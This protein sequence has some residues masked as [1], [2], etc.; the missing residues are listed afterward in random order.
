MTTHPVEHLPAY[1]LGALG[2]EETRN[3]AAHLL[4][5]P[6]CREEVELFRASVGM[7]PGAPPPPAPPQHIKQQLMARIHASKITGH[8]RHSPHVAAKVWSNALT[9]CALLLALIFGVTMVD[10]RRQLAQ[11]Q[12]NTEAL[13]A[14]LSNPATVSQAMESSHPG[15]HGNM[16][17]QFGHT[18]AVLLAGG[19]PELPPG[20]IYQ[21][22]FANSE[23]QIPSVMFTV[24][25]GGQAQAEF[26]APNAVN[27]Y[28][29]VM[30]TVEPVGG[31]TTPS[32]Q[33]VLA[34]KIAV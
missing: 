5:C 34:A 2:P 32:K 9:V 31:S 33:I 15:A 28:D 25:H 29:E 21:F 24:D 23:G 12:Q 11:E 1:A 30:V 6:P 3:V 20:T 8:S 16:Y 27:S 26:D 7:A 13:S 17:M 22:W 18:H 4:V 14:F 19:L 10:T